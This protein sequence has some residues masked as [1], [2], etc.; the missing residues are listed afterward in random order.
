MPPMPS[1]RAKRGDIELKVARK[2]QIRLK[3][4][5][6]SQSIAL[7]PLAASPH[8]D[9]DSLSLASLA[10]SAGRESGMV[11]LSDLHP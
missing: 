5:W 11:A 6:K 4:R 2:L 1:V 10:G 3:T 9:L 8:A 7:K